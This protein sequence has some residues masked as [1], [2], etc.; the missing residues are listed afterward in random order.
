[1]SIADFLLR[2]ALFQPGQKWPGKQVQKA[3][4]RKQPGVKKK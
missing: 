3:K 4:R 2:F 1:M